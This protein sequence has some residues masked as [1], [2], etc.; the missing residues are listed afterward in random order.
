M[1]NYFVTRKYFYAIY[2]IIV[3]V[4][5]LL[6]FTISK[7]RLFFVA[8][9][10]NSLFFD[11][12]FYLITELGNTITYIIVLVLSLFYSRRLT[13][14]LLL[15]LLISSILAQGLKHFVFEEHLRPLAYFGDKF[16]IHHLSISASL[17]M[18][19]FPS[20]H[21]VSAFALATV[22]VGFLNKQKYDLLLL[23]IAILV[24]YSRVYLGQHFVEDVVFGST[25]G[26]FSGVFSNRIF[27]DESKF[28]KPL[29]NRHPR[30]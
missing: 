9:A 20:G 21:T 2:G 10:N 17:K 24:A 15:T 4:L 14:M 18:H 19:S 7:E 30:K 11:Y 12:F 5:A 23:F 25:I 13:F 22:L 3:S 6:C 29:I 16:Q 28:N 1:V 27:H 8:N 26:V